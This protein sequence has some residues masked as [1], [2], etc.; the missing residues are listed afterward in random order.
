MN[1]HPTEQGDLAFDPEEYPHRFPGRFGVTIHKT[2]KADDG[3]TLVCSRNS[4]ESARLID[5]TG[6]VVHRWHYP[7]GLSWHYAEMLGNGHLLAVVNVGGY[8]AKRARTQHLLELDWDSQ[9]VW[10]SSA[11][12]HHDVQRRENGN[13]VLLCNQD[14]LIPGINPEIITY[15]YVQEITPDGTVVWEWHFVDHV[16]ELRN[17][18]RAFGNLPEMYKVR[19]GWDDEDGK[20]ANFPAAWSRDFPHL[21]TV[22]RLPDTPL[23]RQDRRFRAGNLLI[24][25]R[26]LDCICIVDHDTQE[27]VWMWGLGEILGQHHPTMLPDGHIL[28]FDNGKAPPVANRSRCLEIDPATGRIVWDYSADP[29]EAFYAPTGSSNQRLP[30][31]NTVICGMDMMPGRQG[32][33]FEVTPEGEVVWAY[34]SCTESEAPPQSTTMYRAVRY[35]RALIENLI[36]G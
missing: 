24:S 22:E 16:D 11:P 13:T 2:E 18:A 7:Q 14:R 21:N 23:G 15:D 30:N 10:K 33:V 36:E 27:M 17:L 29:P 31:G 20:L 6:R 35:T 9:V 1:T 12:V 8:T 34:W 26:H 4:E 25:P 32:Q 5:M 28:L 19:F 3:Y